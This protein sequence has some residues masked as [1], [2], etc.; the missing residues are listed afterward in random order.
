MSDA[1]EEPL[2]FEPLLPVKQKRQRAEQKRAI[3]KIHT[4]IAEAIAVI[5][6]EGEA[7][8]NLKEIAESTGVSYGAIYHHFGDRGGL[9][10]AAQFER[11]RRQPGL[12]LESLE[13]AL[14]NPGSAIDF[15][16]RIQQIADD[17]A[18]PSRG[19]IRLERASV[20]ASSLSRPDL[21]AALEELEDDVYQ[22]L[23]NLIIEAQ[24]LGLAD[25]AL[26]PGAAAIYL[27]ALSFGVVLM[28]FVENRPT[29]QALS[30]LIFRGF[31][32]LLAQ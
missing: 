16:S 32:A 20:I 12:D 19:A 17:I 31:A 11:L 14:K 27:E 30:N 26:D 6:R 23:R 7:G 24:K 4:V 18:D 9:I 13:A 8:V 1:P 5:E 2:G 22:R 15:V 10:Q 28:E 29:P 25:P 3:E 21:R